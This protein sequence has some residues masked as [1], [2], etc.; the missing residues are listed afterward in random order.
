MPTRW[1]W[2]PRIPGSCAGRKERAILGRGAGWARLLGP[3]WLV[4]G[5]VG[6]PFLARTHLKA[7]WVAVVPAIV[8]ALLPLIVFWYPRRPAVEALFAR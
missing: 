5:I 2:A 4:V 6:A 8:Q 3:R 7:L 1:S